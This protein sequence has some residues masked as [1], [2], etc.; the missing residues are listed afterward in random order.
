MRR[1]SAPL[2]GLLLLAAL[3]AAAT[4]FCPI[5]ATRDGFVALRAG[6]SLGAKIVARMRPGDEMMPTVEERGAWVKARYWRGGERLTRGFGAHRATGWV[7]KSL[8]P[9]LCG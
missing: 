9:D 4:T 8:I 1:W 3:P 5:P 7:H 2:A 6:P